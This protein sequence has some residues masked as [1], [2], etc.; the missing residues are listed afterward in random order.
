[1][2]RRGLESDV[3][4]I[5]ALVHAVVPIMEAC[6]NYQWG[7]NNTE[8]RFYPNVADFEIDAKNGTLWVIDGQLPTSTESTVV[9]V[10]ALTVDQP[11]EY[12]V[13]G[14]DLNLPAVVPHRMAVHPD[15]QGRGVAK[16]LFAKA[17]DLAREVGWNRV[18][19]DTCTRN[20]PM[21]SLIE[22]L[23]YTRQD[24]TFTFPGKAPGLMFCAYEKVVS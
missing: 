5:M 15:Y 20:T 8:G 10:A 7:A 16:Q 12:G 21:N 24:T 19:V 17:E 9:G 6:H 3:P 13:A 2:A 18:R 1:M 22:K 14:L 11:D 23:G 4:A